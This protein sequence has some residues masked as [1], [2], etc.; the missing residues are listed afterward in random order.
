[1]NVNFEAFCIAAITGVLPEHAFE[2]RDNPKAKYV[3]IITAEDKEDMVQLHLNGLTW[4][5][6]AG[7][8]NLTERQVQNL[9]FNYK[10]F[11][12]KKGVRLWG[13]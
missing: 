9:V 7:I 11:L 5:E 13:M 8:Y 1:M 2:L 3:S 4:A 12:A 10:K 6:V